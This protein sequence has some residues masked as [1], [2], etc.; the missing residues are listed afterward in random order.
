METGISIGAPL[1]YLE[2]GS[3]TGDPENMLSKALEMDISFQRGPPFGEME[4]R[5]LEP[6]REGIVFYLAEFL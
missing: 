3:F 4:V 6:L 2:G 5:F 1:G